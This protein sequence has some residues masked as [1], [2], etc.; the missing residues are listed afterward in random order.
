MTQSAIGATDAPYD[1]LRQQRAAINA[2]GARLSALA[3]QPGYVEMHSPRAPATE[4]AKPF[5]GFASLHRLFQGPMVHSLGAGVYLAAKHDSVQRQKQELL[6][7][8]E[9]QHLRKALKRAQEQ[10]GCVDSREAHSPTK[11]AMG[12]SMAPGAGAADDTISIASSSSSSA[13]PPPAKRPKTQSSG[14][15]SRPLIEKRNTGPAL[16]AENLWPSAYNRL[17]NAP[18]GEPAYFWAHPV[19]DDKLGKFV[20]N[21]LGTPGAKSWRYCK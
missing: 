14:T 2:E 13:N 16:K 11:R 1:Q 18:E 10:L 5:A 20:A 12:A 15:R 21:S 8:P 3:R 17:K 19:T 4:G 7:D 6:D 9:A